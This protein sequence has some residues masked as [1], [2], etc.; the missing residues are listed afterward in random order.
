MLA[1]GLSFDDLITALK[2]NNVSIGPGYIEKEGES[3]LIKSDERLD[4]PAQIQDIVVATRNGIPIR[5][6][7]LANVVVGKELRTGSSSKDGYEA[8]VGTAMML[9]GAN[10]RTVSQAVDAKIKEINRT[11]PMI[12]KLFLS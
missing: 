2:K 1:L 4:N 10:S 5:I 9:I 6:H 8:V 12:S 3:F 7:D 11:L